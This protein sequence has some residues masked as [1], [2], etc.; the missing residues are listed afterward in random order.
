MYSII[1]KID[2]NNDGEYVKERRLKLDFATI[3]DIDNRLQVKCG[4][5]F[6]TV[7]QDM[8]NEHINFDN[9]VDI[10]YWGLIK[11]DPKLTRQSLI[12]KLSRSV[13]DGQNDMADI[14]TMIT[15]A[16]KESGVLKSK[17]DDDDEES[18]KPEDK[19]KT[20]LD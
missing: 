20:P 12:N 2:R 17:K 19:E 9:V 13:E 18:K 8:I 15:D 4:K 10:I 1:I 5:D 7:L 16:A 11:D 3:V 6:M 14:L